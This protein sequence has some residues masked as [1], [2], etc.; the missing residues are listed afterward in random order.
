[1]H[2]LVLVC[3]KVR[4]STTCW[5]VLVVAGVGE[6]EAGGKRTACKSGSDGDQFSGSSWLNVE[7]ARLQENVYVRVIGG[8]HGVGAVSRRG[9]LSHVSL[10][11]SLSRD[12]G[13]AKIQAVVAAAVFVAGNSCVLRL[14]VF[15]YL[16]FMS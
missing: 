13:I 8:V 10:C 12:E 5:C 4:S 6:S 7:T 1:M 3:V 16:A 11:V 14:L 9:Y 15:F 2:E